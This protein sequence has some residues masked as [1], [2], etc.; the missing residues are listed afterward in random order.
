[1]C[2]ELQLFFTDMCSASFAWHAQHCFLVIVSHHLHTVWHSVLTA[3]PLLPPPGGRSDGGGYLT[4]GVAAQYL[5]MYPE[6]TPAE[7]LEVLRSMA[8]S[9]IVT[10]VK[11]SP[12]L[13]YTNF[14][15]NEP[16]FEPVIVPP[17]NNGS[18]NGGGQPAQQSGGGS[19]APVAAIVAAVAAGEARAALVCILWNGNC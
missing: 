8:T 13:L 18:G 2:L 1:M 5:S 16:G 12:A 3:D 11:C 4:A 17:P 10:G 7:V 14:T 15:S 19:S 6:A 9:D